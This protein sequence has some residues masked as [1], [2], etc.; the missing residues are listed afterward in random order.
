MIQI[1]FCDL[2]KSD[3]LSR[4]NEGEYRS[5]PAFLD[6]QYRVSGVMGLFNTGF[7]RI[8]TDT[9]AVRIWLDE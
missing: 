6:G 8:V 9:R 5:L 4:E 2:Q 3:V 7:D 1:R